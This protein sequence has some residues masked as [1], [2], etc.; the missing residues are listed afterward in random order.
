MFK[1]F[2][3]L[4]TTTNLELLCVVALIVL[5]HYLILFAID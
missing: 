1:F 5:I 3:T 2:T 4:E